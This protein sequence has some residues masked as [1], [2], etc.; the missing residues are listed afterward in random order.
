[1]PMIEQMEAA[2]KAGALGTKIV[3]SG[4]GGCMLALTNKESKVQVIHAFKD[5]GAA[6]AYEVQ[7]TSHP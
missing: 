7:L 5:A 4:G 1:P 3:G 6:Q 2:K